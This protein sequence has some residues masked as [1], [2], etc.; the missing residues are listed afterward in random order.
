MKGV[1][2][3]LCKNL[4]SALLTRCPQANRIFYAAVAK[5]SIFSFLQLISAGLNV[6]KQS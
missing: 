3:K 6:F 1:P 2:P 5:W 4:T